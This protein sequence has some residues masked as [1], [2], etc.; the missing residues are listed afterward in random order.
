MEPLLAFA[1]DGE[2]NSLQV[3]YLIDFSI[4]PKVTAIQWS[5]PHEDVVAITVDNQV[6]VLKV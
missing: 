4:S 2:I 1:A 6:Q 3:A 5:E